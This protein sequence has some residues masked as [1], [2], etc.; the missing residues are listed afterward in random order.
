MTAT[1][2]GSPVSNEGGGY[3]RPYGGRM[4]L[5][6]GSSV[7]CSDAAFGR[8][9]D[10]VVDPAARRVTHLVVEADA[11]GGSRLVPVTLARGGEG[12]EIELSCTLDEARKLPAIDMLDYLRLG[13]FPVADPDW[14][15]GISEMLALPYYQPV[16]LPGAGLPDY[17]QGMTVRY[18][19]VPKGEVE[20]RRRS[21]VSSSDGHVLGHVDGFVVDDEQQISHVVL[22]HGH[23]WGR[24]EIAIPIG[25][26]TAVEDDAVALSLTKAEV[27]ALE[28]VSLD[29]RHLRHRRDQ[30]G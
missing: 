22:E 8:L 23:L 13:E 5:D 29:R 26:V 7:R 4:R 6:L 14:D 30:H 19:R 12:S 9:E 2:E 25:A 15:V 17:E 16:D 20:I 11:H 24:H 28:R 10:V 1:A 18:H 3:A 21:A 27:G